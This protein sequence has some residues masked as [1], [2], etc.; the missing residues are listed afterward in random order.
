MVW[1]LTQAKAAAQDSPATLE[2]LTALETLLLGEEVLLLQ[3]LKAQRQLVQGTLMVAATAVRR[4]A[5]NLATQAQV[6][7]VILATAVAMRIQEQPIK[8]V[9]AAAVQVAIGR[10]TLAVV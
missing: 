2:T 6:Q 7:V 9:Q 5:I 3:T 4:L 8:M 1:A 10:G